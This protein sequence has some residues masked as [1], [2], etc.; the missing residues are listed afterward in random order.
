MVEFI[1]SV[2]AFHLFLKNWYSF[3]L[4]QFF[5]IYN[6]NDNLERLKMR[7]FGPRWYYIRVGYIKRIKI[8]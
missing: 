2:P 7:L 4:M 8:I 5:Q 6:M 1:T 3:S